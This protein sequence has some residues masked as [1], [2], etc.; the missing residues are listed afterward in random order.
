V[1]GFR[2]CRSLRFPRFSSIIIAYEN[3]NRP[4]SWHVF[5]W[6]WEYLLA[7]PNIWFGSRVWICVILASACPRDCSFCP[8]LLADSNIR[9]LFKIF[10]ALYMIC[11]FFINFGISESFKDVRKICV[12]TFCHQWN[13]NI[14]LLHYWGG[15]IF[16]MKSCGETRFCEYI[17]SSYFI[18][19]W[20]SGH[21]I[22]R[23]ETLIP[24]YHGHFAY[25][26]CW[27]T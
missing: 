4:A 17:W 16:E 24:C 12:L 25:R 22:N 18:D 3:C 6:F 26:C 9:I 19:S 1:L 11:A 8:N 15:A 23:T 2:Q 21:C 5:Q 7:L 13:R 27:A 10:S 14:Y 20:W